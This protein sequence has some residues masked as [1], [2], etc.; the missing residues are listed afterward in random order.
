M[1]RAHTE[2]MRSQEPATF[3]PARTDGGKDSHTHRQRAVASA[4]SDPK[5]LSVASKLARSDRFE[6]SGSI[7]R[8]RCCGRQQREQEAAPPPVLNATLPMR[9]HSGVHHPTVLAHPLECVRVCL[10]VPSRCA[11]LRCFRVGRRSVRATNT[12]SS[13]S[14][15]STAAAVRHTNRND[16]T[17]NMRVPL[18]SDRC[19]NRA[20]TAEQRALCG[21]GS[22][23]HSAESAAASAAAAGRVCAAHLRD[24]PAVEPLLGAAAPRPVDSAVLCLLLR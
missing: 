15:F 11:A 23:S 4:Q 8:T 3:D 13:S 9:V 10:R 2:H 6:C 16:D 14:G 18:T 5:S 21:H 24:Y 22:L 19:S 1:S 20:H 17:T 7:A 12:D